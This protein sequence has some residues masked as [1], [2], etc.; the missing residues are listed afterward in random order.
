MPFQAMLGINIV[1]YIIK[2]NKVYELW[3]IG[4]SFMARRKK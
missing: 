4:V 3:L 2:F 1:N